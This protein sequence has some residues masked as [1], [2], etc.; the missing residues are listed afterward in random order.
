MAGLACPPAE[1]AA[2]AGHSV[3]ILLATCTLCLPGYS[4]IAS[5]H[6]DRALHASTGPPLAHKSGHHPG[7][8][9]SVM[10]PCHSWTRGDT[11]GPDATRRIQGDT[12]DLHKHGR[13]QEEHEPQAHDR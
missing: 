6:I 8:T 5:Q 7:Q 3:H 4:Q 11:A 2:R 9:P 13:G 1:I 10:R 12:R